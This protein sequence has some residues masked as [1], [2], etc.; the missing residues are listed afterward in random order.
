M[1][2]KYN[3]I[4]IDDHPIVIEGL[5]ILLSKIDNISIE[6][7]FNLGN[8]VFEFKDLSK[9]DIVL[10][11]VFLPD[12]NGIDLCLKLKKINPKIIVLA[13]SSQSERSIV[14]QMIKSGANGYL[15]KSASTEEF[16]ECI[17]QTIEGKLA[18]SNEVKKI[19]E[20][21][22]IDDLK[23]IPRL[24]HREKDILLL[25]KKGKSTQEISDELFLSFLTIQ[26]HR[27]NLLTKFQV[28]NIIELI[29]FV[30]KNGLL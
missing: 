24:T 5:M 3:L 23:L 2:E 25:L 1:K 8:S 30:D 11:D 13:I 9:I 6:A 26:T 28:R 21:T 20:K 17:K 14:M 16:K 19:V 18:F 7:T 4:I 12:I 15:L 29:N 10:L 27:R 22:S